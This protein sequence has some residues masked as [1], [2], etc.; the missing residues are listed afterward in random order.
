MLGNP[1][2]WYLQQMMD[3]SHIG[4][5]L[6]LLM[7]L[8]SFLQTLK[9]EEYEGV[10]NWLLLVYIYVYQKWI[11]PGSLFRSNLGHFLTS[12]FLGFSLNIIYGV[13]RTL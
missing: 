9:E 2:E 6:I 4:P 8:S 3:L 11:G 1:R 5:L 10:S 12:K 7:C 13:V